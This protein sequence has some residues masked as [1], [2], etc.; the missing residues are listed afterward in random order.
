MQKLGTTLL[1]KSV[2]PDHDSLFEKRKLDPESRDMRSKLLGYVPDVSS[3]IKK[4]EE[5]LQQVWLKNTEN[6]N[7]ITKLSPL[8]LVF[9]VVGFYFP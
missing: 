2:H 9:V 7:S 4:L 6:A 3:L 8:L 1:A 5:H